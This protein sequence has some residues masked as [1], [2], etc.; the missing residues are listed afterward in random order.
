MGILLVSESLEGPSRN[1]ISNLGK[2]KACGLSDEA[3]GVLAILNRDSSVT[4]FTYGHQLSM[5]CSEF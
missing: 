5:L 1:P 2:A 4:T 3:T